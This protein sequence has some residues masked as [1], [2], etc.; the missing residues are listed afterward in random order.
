MRAD[1]D[2][3]LKRQDLH[4]DDLSEVIREVERLVAAHRV[5]GKWTLAQ[6]CKHL[7]DSIHGSMDGFDLRRHRF[8]RFFLAKIMLRFTYWWGIPPGYTV[9]PKLTPPEEV[10]LDRAVSELQHAIARYERHEGALAPHPLFG[11]LSRPG[12]D[13]MHRFHCAHHL[14]FVV[15][16]GR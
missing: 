6:V 13:R 9:D 8:K 12:W 4:F 15:P 10:D 3:M 7:A 14:R 2:S 11:E 5:V 16:T 1:S